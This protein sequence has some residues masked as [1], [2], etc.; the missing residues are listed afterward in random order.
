[1]YLGS[2]CYRT[3]RSVFL[4]VLKILN[5][6][7]RVSYL[8]ITPDCSGIHF[9]NEVTDL[10]FNKNVKKREVIIHPQKIFSKHQKRVSLY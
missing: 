8:G 10:I 9:C 4:L 5:L 3:S 7:N 1:M 6:K 2:T